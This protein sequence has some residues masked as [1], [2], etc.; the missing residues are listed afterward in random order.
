MWPNDV[1]AR[2]IDASVRWLPPDP[3]MRIRMRNAEP[4]RVLVTLHQGGGS[5][6]VNSTLHLALG[7]AEQG[8]QVRFACPPDSP[9]AVEAAARGLEVHPLALEPRRRWA[10]AGRLADLLARHPVDLINAQS[11][12]DREAFTLLGVTGRLPAPLVL[13]RRSWPRTTPL[14]NWFAGRVVRAGDRGQRAG[15]GRA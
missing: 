7:L 8:I 1:A 5:G 10:N 12:R 4:I 13:T 3:T 9:V 14:E 11:S 6:A 15:T 2:A